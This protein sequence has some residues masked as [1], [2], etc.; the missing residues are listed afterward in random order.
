MP[1]SQIVLDT[2]R[3]LLTEKVPF[4]TYTAKATEAISDGDAVSLLLTG[5]A[6][7]ISLADSA[8]AI[9]AELPVGIAMNDAAAGDMVEVMIWGIHPTANVQ[10]STTEGAALYT[11]AVA[12]QLD[13]APAVGP[14]VAIALA[15]DTA[16][17]APVYVQSYIDAA[18]T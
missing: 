12:G 16:N 13:D 17:V 3:T 9:T 18:I 15:A 8:V 14:L 1:R 7:T 6:L 2:D 10:A 11:S 4:M 5:G